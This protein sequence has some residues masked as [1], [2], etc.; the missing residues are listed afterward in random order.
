MA[1]LYIYRNLRTGGFSVRHLGKVI[2]RIDTAVAVGVRFKV[3]LAGR[4]RVLWERQKNV[5]SFVVAAS[6]NRI[7]NPM[8]NNHEI[9]YNPYLTDT[10]TIN[11]KPIHHASSVLFLNGK[12]Y[13]ISQ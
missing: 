9:K 5:H 4:N 3:N 13:L 1:H 12:C 2:C 8:S 6:L 7:T 11:G 10:F